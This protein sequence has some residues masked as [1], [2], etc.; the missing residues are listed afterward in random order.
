MPGMR[1]EQFDATADN[2][3]LRACFEMTR[4]GWPVDHPDQP[5]W[6]FEP[7]AGK[8]A[9]GFDTAPRQTWLARDDTGEPVGGY[10][11]QLPET[12]NTSMAFCI[13]IVAPAARRSGVGRALLAHCADQARRAGRSRLAGTARDDAPGAAFAAAVGARPGIAEVERVLKVDSAFPGRLSDL[14]AEA[15]K[16]SAGYSLLSWGASAP[17]EYLDQLARMHSAMADAPR[18]AGVEPQVWDAARV[19]HL[20][21]TRA[22]HKLPCYAVAARHDATGELVALTE[23]LTEADIP[24]WAFQQ[25]TAVLPDHRGHRLGLLVKVA[26]LEQLLTREPAVRYI[27]TGNAGSNAHMIAINE[28]LG[29]TVTGAGRDWELDL[30]DESAAAQS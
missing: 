17:A 10:L 4:A 3:R 8:W 28:Q 5:P 18:D 2:V 21:Q 16:H 1:M 12:E 29:F 23:M 22:E 11:L 19:R 7:F 14:R 25:I 26:M 27:L 20:E 15:E 24:D 6:A 9:R 30:A 13:L